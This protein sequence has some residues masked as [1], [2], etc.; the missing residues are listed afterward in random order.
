MVAALVAGRRVALSKKQ[1][2]K[3]ESKQVFL[4]LLLA[5]GR[6]PSWFLS[7][8]LSYCH[9]AARYYS[10]KRERDD[11]AFSV[12]DSSTKGTKVIEESR[13]GKNHFRGP[14]AR[15]RRRRLSRERVF[16]V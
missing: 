5:D 4:E 7:S 13:R 6:I 16:F 14:N 2:S 3:W 12:R 9:K 8:P 10:I 15:R 1:K 11:G